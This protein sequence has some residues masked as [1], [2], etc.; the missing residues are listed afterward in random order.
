M[1]RTPPEARLR[2]AAALC[3]SRRVGRA[4]IRPTRGARHDRSRSARRLLQAE[5]CWKV[6]VVVGSDPQKP[7]GSPP[8]D[9][10][11]DQGICPGQLRFRGLWAIGRNRRATRAR[12][13]LRERECCGPLV[14]PNKGSMSPVGRMQGTS[15]TSGDTSLATFPPRSPA[16]ATERHCSRVFARGCSVASEAGATV[17]APLNRHSGA[18]LQWSPGRSRSR[19][20]ERLPQPLALT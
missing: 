7:R 17:H 11:S 16:T 5:R 12:V 9:T 19:W 1:W 3:P 15:G 10:N 18:P 2:S 6:W 4:T 13:R 14:L 20:R 8:F